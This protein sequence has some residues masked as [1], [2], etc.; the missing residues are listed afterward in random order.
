MKIAL[1]LAFTLLAGAARAS[2]VPAEFA[3]RQLI[4]SQLPMQALLRDTTGQQGSLAQFTAGL[5]AIIAL[6]YYHCPNLCGLVRDDLLHALAGSGLIAGK[7]YTLVVLSIDPHETPHDAASAKDADI[8]RYDLPG[9]HT[10]WHYLTAPA[11][12]IDAIS[13]AVGFRANFDAASAQFMHPA[14]IV[15]LTPSGIVSGY[16]LGLGYEPVDIR[17][18]IARARLSHLARA[19]L[20]ILLLC[21]HFDPTTGRYSLAILRV[22]QI[23]GALTVLTVGGTIMLTLR[24]ERRGQ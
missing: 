21:F 2:P 1:V 3:Y 10:G 23:A 11:A 13:Q 4:G 15:F 14:G 19:S 16:R 7:D 5:P 8:A 17:T 12:T 9:A 24:R 20:P 6:G 22:L 18:G